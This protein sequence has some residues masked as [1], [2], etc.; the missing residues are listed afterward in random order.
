M[1]ENNHKSPPIPDSE[2]WAEYILAVKKTGLTPQLEKARER[3]SLL[4][5]THPADVEGALRNSYMN[6]EI[7]S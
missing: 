7:A 4:L 3:I 2:V 6:L 1:Q 5:T